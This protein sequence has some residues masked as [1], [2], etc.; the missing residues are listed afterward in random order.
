MLENT[1]CTTDH[2][3]VYQ[4]LSAVYAG[5]EEGRWQRIARAG[6]CVHG[7]TRKTTNRSKF[8]FQLDFLQLYNRTNCKLFFSGFDFYNAN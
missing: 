3:R 8:S 1:N 5:I 4:S 7:N 2:S 6:T